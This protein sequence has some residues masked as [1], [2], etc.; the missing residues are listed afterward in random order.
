MLAIG[1]CCTDICQGAVPA[2]VPFLVAERGYS[3]GSA[4]VLVVAVT[5][6]SSVVQPA[7]GYIS[8]LRSVAWLLPAGCVVAG[9]GIGL[10]GVMPSYWLTVLVVA[11][12]GFGI[13]AYHPEGSRYASYLSTERRATAM[14]LFS[15]GGNVGFA[16]GPVLMAGV[17]LLF[18]LDGTL[19]IGLIAIAAGGLIARELVLLR[20]LRPPLSNN[21]DDLSPRSNDWGSFT[22]L[23]MV[24]GLRSSIYFGLSML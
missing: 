7:F 2:M 24:I 14:S 9:L 17:T 10:A 13:A 16:L 11:A 18:G 21:L 19:L 1:H 6:S 5:I 12:G 4:S 22:K 23:V 8:D 20:S 3:V 15:V